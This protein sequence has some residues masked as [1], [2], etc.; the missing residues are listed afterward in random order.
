MAQ[1]TGLTVT[2]LMSWRLKWL[3]WGDKVNELTVENADVVKCTNIWQAISIYGAWHVSFF[4]WF[5]SQIKTSLRLSCTFPIKTSLLFSF[6]HFQLK[7]IVRAQPLSMSER[8]IYIVISTVNTLVSFTWF[9]RRWFKKIGK[10]SSSKSL[11][12]SLFILIS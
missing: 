1:I 5:L 9:A 4:N 2:R 8:P 10:C 11:V 6:L 3:S 7:H 12:D